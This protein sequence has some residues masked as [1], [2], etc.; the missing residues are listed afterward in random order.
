VLLHEYDKAVTWARTV[1]LFRAEA[2]DCRNLVLSQSVV[3]TGTDGGAAHRS[4]ASF[5]PYFERASSLTSTS[6]M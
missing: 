4:D 1:R 2:P 3:L 6:G 5:F